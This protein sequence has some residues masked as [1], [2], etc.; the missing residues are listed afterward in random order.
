MVSGEWRVVRGGYPVL[1]CCSTD[2][3]SAGSADESLGCCWEVTLD[4]WVL[5]SLFAGVDGLPELMVTADTS[6]G[7]MIPV[8][9]GFVCLYHSQPARQLIIN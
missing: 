2:C 7:A 8:A 3:P 1:Y 5:T 9:D 4:F 6:C